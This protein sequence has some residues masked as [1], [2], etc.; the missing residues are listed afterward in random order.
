MTVAEGRAKVE[1]THVEGSD[2]RHNVFLFALSTC[3]WC[4]RTR[5][6]LEE[7]EIDY[8]YIYVDQL[9]GEEREEALEELKKWTSRRAFP[10]VVV[11]EDDVLVGLDK[12]KLRESLDL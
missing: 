3:G 4:A 9:K 1:T 2:T 5:D 12:D 7:N 10:T 6:F 11:D 8:D